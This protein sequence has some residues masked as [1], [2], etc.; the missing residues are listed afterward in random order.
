LD[1]QKEE[2]DFGGDWGKYGYFESSFDQWKRPANPISGA[3]CDVHV[4][5]NRLAQHILVD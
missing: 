2:R 5:N 4:P 3:A 1:D